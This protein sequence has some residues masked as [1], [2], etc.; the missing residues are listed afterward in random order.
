VNTRAPARLRPAAPA[1]G[2]VDVGRPLQTGTESAQMRAWFPGIVGLEGG[3]SAP[4]PLG[5]GVCGG[6]A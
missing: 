1:A 2:T 4:H 3:G 6:R 5:G